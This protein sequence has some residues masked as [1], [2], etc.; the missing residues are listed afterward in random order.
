MNSVPRVRVISALIVC[1]VCASRLA[2]AGEN[3]RTISTSGEAIVYVVPDQAIATVGVQ[4]T[5]ASLDRAKSMNDEASQRLVKAIKALGVED[6]HV[7]TDHV[8][9]ELRYEHNRRVISAF[10]VT[11]AYMVTLKDINKLEPLVDT[12]LKSGANI[13]QGVELRSSELRKNR[14]QAR[15]MAIKAAKEKAVALA[16]ELDCAVGAPRTISESGGS[17]YPM[18]QRYN[19]A[20]NISQDMGGDGGEGGETMP[21][22]QIAIRATVSVT[23]DLVPQ[24]RKAE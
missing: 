2:R 19:V 16:S 4:T 8:Q 18:A 13:L 17:W 20:Q 1:A 24:A 21:L 10:V 12:A 5:D 3:L 15:S 23:F 6:R 7:G 22:G 11:R 14:D 9:V